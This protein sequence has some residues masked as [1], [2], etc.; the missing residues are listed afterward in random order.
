[1]LDIIVLLAMPFVLVGY[2]IASLFTYDKWCPA[3]PYILLNI[4]AEIVGALQ[5]LIGCILIYYGYSLWGWL[6]MAG[7]SVLFFIYFVLFL[8]WDSFK[9]KNSPI[10][11]IEDEDE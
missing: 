5:V 3:G 1:M 8:I 9:N 6:L 4:T 7:P 11:H 2:P 10:L